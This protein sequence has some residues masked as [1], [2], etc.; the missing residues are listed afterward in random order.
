VSGLGVQLGS[1]E[2]RCQDQGALYVAGDA[3]MVDCDVSAAAA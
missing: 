3:T 2:I 1:S